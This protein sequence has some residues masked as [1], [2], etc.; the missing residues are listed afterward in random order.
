MGAVAPLGP[1]ARTRWRREGQPRRDTRGSGTSLGAIR[2][3]W[4]TRLWPSRRRGGT[5]ERR[6]RRGGL[7]AAL[8]CSGKQSREL[9]KGDDQ[10]KGTDG[11]LTLRGSAGVAKQRRRSRDSMG[12]RR[13]G[14]GCA[15]IASVSVDRT[16]QRGK[17]H[18]EGCPEQLT[19]RQSSPWHWT[20]HGRDGGHRTGSGRWWAVAE[21]PARV[22]RARERA[23]GLGEQGT[24]LKRGA[25][26]QTWPENARTW[27]RP[28]RGDRGRG[29]EDELTSGDGGTERAGA[30]E[31]TAPTSLAH[32]AARERERERERE[33]GRAGWRR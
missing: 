16:Q 2:A 24:G 18:T 9:Q 4:R 25:G 10:I 5:R 31:R 1:V 17:G 12:R 14:S 23:R 33:R 32:G 28:R 15:K 8:D 21:L 6:P 27:A 13:G 3:V 22:G 11:L 26:A 30:R 19:V 29:V 20:G 7:T